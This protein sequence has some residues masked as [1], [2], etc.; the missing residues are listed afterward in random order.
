MNKCIYIEA[1][2]AIYIKPKNDPKNLANFT[3]RQCGKHQYTL[4]ICISL[5]F[6]LFVKQN[7]NFVFVGSEIIP[8]S[9]NIFY[10]SIASY[11][12]LL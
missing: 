3:Y 5:Q 12:L 11:F 9:S 4:C 7:R 6:S 10:L 8:K 2:F 1:Y